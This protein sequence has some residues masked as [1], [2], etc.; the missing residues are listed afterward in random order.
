[1]SPGG[2]TP[3]GD[4]PDRLSSPRGSAPRS[5]GLLRRFGTGVPG[6]WRTGGRQKGRSKGP[7]GHQGH[8]GHEEGPPRPGFLVLDVLD[9]LEV[10]FSGRA[11]SL[12]DLLSAPRL[13]AELGGMERWTLP[14]ARWNLPTARWNLSTERWN[15]PTAR[16][17]LPT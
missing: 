5:H 15:L 7:Q 17:N 3:W 13:P 1:M 16:W 9:V 8:Q 10:L 12:L 6:M 14:T 4:L 2:D 11:R